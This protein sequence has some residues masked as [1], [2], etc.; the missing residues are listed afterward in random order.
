MKLLPIYFKR[1]CNTFPS[2]LNAKFNKIFTPLIEYQQNYWAL[3]VEFNQNRF[4]R[5][6]FHTAMYKVNA[7]A[8]VTN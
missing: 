7:H 1:N 2:L 3:G 5:P 6:I 8:Y 4:S